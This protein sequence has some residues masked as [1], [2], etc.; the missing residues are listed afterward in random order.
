LNSR[1][2][3]APYIG[4]A[5]MWIKSLQREQQCEAETEAAHHG[6]EDELYTHVH[7]QIA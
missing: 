7:T 3:R 4:L 6:R 2:K 1:L 5:G